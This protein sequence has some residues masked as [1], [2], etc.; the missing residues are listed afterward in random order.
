MVHAD[1]RAGLPVLVDGEVVGR[2]NARGVAHLALHRPSNT[3]FR[4]ALDTSSRPRLRPRNPEVP[5]AVGDADDIFVFDQSFEQLR[6]RKR[7][8][9]RKRANKAVKPA[10]PIKIES[11]S[12]RRWRSL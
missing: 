6:V 3:T 5:F 1:G 10:R 8:R 2:T 12:K 4:V 9:H 7:R 11:S